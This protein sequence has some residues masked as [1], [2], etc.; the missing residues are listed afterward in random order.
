L[1][2][3]FDNT[4]KKHLYFFSKSVLLFKEKEIGSN[5]MLLAA[6]SMPLSAAQPPSRAHDLRLLLFSIG[7][8]LV[9]ALLFGH[10]IDMVIFMASGYLVGTGQNPYIAQD[11]SS[12]FHSG[13]FRHL[14]TI[15]YPPPWPLVLGLVY[16]CVYAAVPNVLLYNLAAKIPII[17]A[18]VALAYTTERFLRSRGAADHI[19]RGARASLLLNPLLLYASAAWGQF[20]SVVAL[21]SLM[22][23]IALVEHKEVRSAALLALAVS[24]KPTAL[25]LPLVAIAYLVTKSYIRALRYGAVFSAVSIFL[26]VVP[27]AV[28]KWD[29][30]VIIRHWNAHLLLGGCMSYMSFYQFANHTFVLTGNWR[31]LGMAWIPALVMALVAIR[32]EIASPL[33]LFKKSVALVLIFFLS[34]TWLSEQNVLLILPLVLILTSLGE[35]NRRA[36]T[37]IWALPLVFSFFNA[38]TPLLFFPSMPLLMEKMTAFAHV[39]ST[40]LLIARSVAVVAWI[41]AGSRIAIACFMKSPAG[42]KTRHLT[43]GYTSAGTELRIPLFDG[44]ALTIGDVA[45][46]LGEYPTSALQKGLILSHGGLNLTEEA[47]GF[48]VPVLKRGLQTIFPS[49][50]ELASFQ[51]KTVWEVTAIF[52]MNLE[53]KI[54]G[55][56][57]AQSEKHWLCALRNVLAALMRRVALSRYILTVASSTLRRHFGWKTSY[58]SSKFSAKVT[59]CYIVTPEAG[60]VDIE[61][62][63]SGLAVAGVTEIV[64]MN[65]L[66]AG[67]FDR[68]RD[69]SGITLN[70]NKVGMWDEVKAET[71]SFESSEH[72]ISFTLDRV[73]GAK[74][75]RG[76]ELVDS[77]LAWTGFGY[78]FPPS[79]QPFRYTL[80][81]ERA[82]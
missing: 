5:D 68:Y 39:H 2:T 32:G 80:R 48:G 12:V 20:D 15:G 46:A 79:D 35:L 40:P 52:T 38:S 22:S 60:R 66:G 75:Y 69:S 24:L 43:K 13:Y 17:A 77:R 61:A 64:L 82:P 78:S 3:I 55:P 23:I 72:K 7:L 51:R 8:Q 36:F 65:E 42:V 49:R 21:V 50:V 57:F 70:S 81:I 44:F 27:F 62:T 1:G 29:P 58:G 74:L 37:A 56:S 4:V 53:E 14:T 31:I 34:R 11:L 26:C 59:L 6:S 33:D 45:G 18:N 16:K 67:H 9:L 73:K 28:F 47:V 19:A 30:T 25:P 10:L 71:A 76:R 41:F 54:A 63:S